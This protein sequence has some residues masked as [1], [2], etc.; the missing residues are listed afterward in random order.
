[1]L[2][3]NLRQFCGSDLHQSTPVLTTLSFTAGRDNFIVFIKKSRHHTC[4]DLLT[5]VMLH[6]QRQV[7]FPCPNKGIQQFAM[8]E[9]EIRDYFIDTSKLCTA[10]YIRASHFWFCCYVYITNS[11][12]YR[13]AMNMALVA[14]MALNTHSLTHYSYS[15]ILIIFTRKTNIIW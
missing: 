11:Y 15:K 13:F 3:R 2:L 6:F 14:D 10:G 12:N 4:S 8:S 1:M 5:C 9:S 7:N